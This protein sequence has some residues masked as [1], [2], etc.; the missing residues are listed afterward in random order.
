MKNR[1]FIQHIVSFVF[2]PKFLEIKDE[3]NVKSILEKVTEVIKLSYCVYKNL[4][5][6]ITYVWQNPLDISY[7]QP[8]NQ[9]QNT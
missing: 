9:T 5:I 7:V 8:N 6:N 3:K 1:D 2:C 4:R